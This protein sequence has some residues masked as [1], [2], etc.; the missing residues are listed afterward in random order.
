MDIFDQY[1]MFLLHQNLSP[2]EIVVPTCILLGLSH[3]GVLSSLTIACIQPTIISHYSIYLTYPPN[4]LKVQLP[5]PALPL[6]NILPYPCWPL[7]Q[8]LY[9]VGVGQAT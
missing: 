7:Q 5:P 6:I 8:S 4:P 9:G 1:Q 2:T 3:T